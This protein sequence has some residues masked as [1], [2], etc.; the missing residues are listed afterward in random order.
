MWHCQICKFR[1]T[2]K[3]INSIL[4]HLH[5]VHGIKSNRENG[6]SKEFKNYLKFCVNPKCACGCGKDVELHKRKLQFNLFANN[7]LNKK[8]FINPSCPEFHIFNG[9][10]VEQTIRYIS[11][12]QSKDITKKHKLSLRRHNL[13]YNN[14]SSYVTLMQN[15]M[16]K[17][18]VNNLLSK[19]T[20]GKLNGFYGKK[21][22]KETLYALALHRSKQAKIVSKP[23]LIVLGM[24]YGLKKVFEYQHPIDVYIVD[25][26]MSNNVI[27]VYGDYWHSDRFLCGKKVI[28][29]RIKKEELEKLGF[30]LIVIWESEII[31]TPEL[32]VNKLRSIN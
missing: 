23:E 30:N 3:H 28:R 22:K 31:K 21:H 20:S 2:S 9:C 5:D 14:P 17:D 10:S 27:E 19:R 29:D 25:F 18:E 12:L 4:N 7:C 24:L 6:L 8:R 11:E 26:I 32:V 16:T 15:G 13:G 1:A